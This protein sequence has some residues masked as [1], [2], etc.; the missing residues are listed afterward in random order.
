M[1]ARPPPLPAALPRSA[2]LLRFPPASHLPLA[3]CLFWNIPI[4]AGERQKQVLGQLELEF[5]SG[6]RRQQAGNR[7]AGLGGL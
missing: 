4:T 6:L 2:A 3:P 5:Q 1:P 7:T